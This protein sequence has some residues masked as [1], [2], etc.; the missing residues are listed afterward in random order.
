MPNL[1][2]MAGLTDD[3]SFLVVVPDHMSPESAVEILNVAIDKANKEF[4]AKKFA[5]GMFMSRMN[6]II[7]HMSEEGLEFIDEEELLVTKVWDAPLG[8]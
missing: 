2:R 4:P 6:S 8:S 5:S 7:R 3:S 1:V